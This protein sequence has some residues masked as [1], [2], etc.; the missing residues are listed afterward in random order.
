MDGELSIMRICLPICDLDLLTS[1]SK[2][3]SLSLIAPKL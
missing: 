1:K 2:F 3:I